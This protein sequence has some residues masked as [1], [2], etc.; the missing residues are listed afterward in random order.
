MQYLG[1]SGSLGRFLGVWTSLNNALYAYSGIET[2]T[3]AAGETRSP[4]QAIPR[5]AKRIFIRILVFYGILSPLT[6]FGQEMN[7]VVFYTNLTGPC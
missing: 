6:I 3:V 4:R 5:A 7:F 1:I 2:I